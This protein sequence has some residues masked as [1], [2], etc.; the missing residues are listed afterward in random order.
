MVGCSYCNRYYYGLEHKVKCK[1]LNCNKWVHKK[2]ASL[3]KNVNLSTW[4]CKE[5]KGTE[6]GSYST[7]SEIGNLIIPNPE[8]PGTS[9]QYSIPLFSSEHPLMSSLLNHSHNNDKRTTNNPVNNNNNRESNANIATNHISDE[10]S[11]STC[12]LEV[13]SNFITCKACDN[14]RHP[15]CIA[16]D[17]EGT[18]DSINKTFV[19]NMCINL[20]IKMRNNVI[21]VTNINVINNL[22]QN[23]HH[24]ANI[25]Q[26]NLIDY[27]KQ[28]L[29]SFNNNI[30]SNLYRDF[31]IP[32]NHDED[33]SDDDSDD[34]EIPR[35]LTLTPSRLDR[36]NNIDDNVINVLNVN[37]N[38]NFTSENGSALEENVHE[39]YIQLRD[40]TEDLNQFIDKENHQKF[41]TH[42]AIESEHKYIIDVIENHKNVRI[43]IQI[44]H[45]LRHKLYLLNDKVKKIYN[46]LNVR[47]RKIDIHDSISNRSKLKQLI[48]SSIHHSHS[49]SMPLNADDKHNSMRNI[50]TACRNKS[51]EPDEIRSTIVARSIIRKYIKFKV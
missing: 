37:N 3:R 19:C 28:S 36:R 22:N 8:D 51:Q 10:K 41:L 2:C 23:N 26:Q 45:T 38:T 21:N 20:M 17:E 12:K 44:N 16:R 14:Y 5:H 27:S 29:N 6:E 34:E 40:A 25:Q 15:L 50:D 4:S 42:I 33:Y 31:R 9:E 48:T 35:F 30:Q 1:I 18:V 13:G 11:C 32:I 49:K 47:H 43:D 7:E 46:R 39:S 24:A